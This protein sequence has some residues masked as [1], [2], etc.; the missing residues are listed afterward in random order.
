MKQIISHE[1]NL[2]KLLNY[3]LMCHNFKDTPDIKYITT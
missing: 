2:L 3:D 1:V